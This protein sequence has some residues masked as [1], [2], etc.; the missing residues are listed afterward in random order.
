M[1]E[2][3]HSANSNDLIKLEKHEGL[4]CVR[5][6]FVNKIDRAI[7][8]IEKQRSFKP[9]FSP[10]GVIEAA[11]VLSVVNTPTQV[12][13]LM[14]Y[15]EGVTGEDFAVHST[16]KLISALSSSLSSI[17]YHE[18]ERSSNNVIKLSVF[19]EKVEEVRQST[20]DLDLIALVDMVLREVE[21]FP[22]ELVFPIGPCHGDLT[23]SNIIVTSGSKIT[24]IDFLHTYLE[25]PLQDVAKLMQEF[26]YGWS[27]RKASP[28]IQLK[29]KIF[30]S[31]F[32]PR[33]LIMLEDL[34]PDPIRLVNMVNL[35]R[36]A[37]YVKDQSTKYWL[38]KSVNKC[39]GRK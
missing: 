37:P 6:I 24:L 26:S 39:L 5:K 30:C 15:I 25:T 31:Q 12:D 13:I 14:P 27:F 11:P 17:I 29:A 33:A 7:R 2:L 21:G 3:Y 19:T 9:I 34:Y 35:I 16:Q 1:A 32:Y 18:I 23:L 4:P 38:L 10:I 20:T 8:S 22:K 36:I 28:S